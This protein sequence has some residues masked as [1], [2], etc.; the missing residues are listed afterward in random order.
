MCN[1]PTVLCRF[2]CV[3]QWRIL[4][5]LIRF[6]CRWCNRKDISNKL[7]L[8]RILQKFKSQG[9]F[10]LVVDIGA[11]L[12]KGPI[13][14][15][16]KIAAR[17]CQNWGPIEVKSFVKCLKQQNNGD[18]EISSNIRNMT[19]TENVYINAK[20]RKIVLKTSWNSTPAIA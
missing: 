11:L 14:S 5:E 17:S 4:A 2:E 9:L 15:G 7:S 16:N 3:V 12:P 13:L 18:L 20:S 10:E 8:C 1:F 19:K 6:Y